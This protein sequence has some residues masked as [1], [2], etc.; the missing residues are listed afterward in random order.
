VKVE[1]E[2][3]YYWADKLGVLVWQDMPN[4]RS[5]SPKSKR[6][7]EAELRELVE[8]KRNHPSIAMWV[9]FN[10]GWGQFEVPRFAQFVKTLDPT[11]LVN[12][13]SGSHDS[14]EGDVHDTHRFPLPEARA[15]EA[16][17]A[18]VVGKFGGLNERVPGHVWGQT[19]AETAFP[20]SALLARNFDKAMLQAWKLKDDPGASAVIFV[21]LTDVENELNGLLTYDRAILKTSAERITRANRGEIQE[22][23]PL[24]MLAETS[25]KTPAIWKYTTDKPG[26]DW[27][28]PEF[29]DTGW[30]NGEGAFGSEGMTHVKTEWKTPDIWLRREI[31][32]P[33]NLK[34]PVLLIQHDDDFMLYINGVLAAQGTNSNQTYGEF[35]LAPDAVAALK[36]GKNVIAITVKNTGGPGFID[37]GLGQIE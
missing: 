4:G 3:W 17:R 30:K 24:Q 34:T 18:S 14:G 31:E 2:R 29:D 9:L 35:P 11:R 20:P 7:F 21:Q 23:S 15:P 12:S 37:A 19:P 13:A 5:D 1:P 36:P 32:L 33:Q 10:E 25:Q 28:K 16:T 22:I 27:M 6:Q 26:A 8:G